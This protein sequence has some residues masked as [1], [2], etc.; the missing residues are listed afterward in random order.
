MLS[1]RH[2]YN[3]GFRHY[4]HH[5]LF[6]TTAFCAVSLVQLTVQTSVDLRI[7]AFNFYVV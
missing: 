4:I 1:S 2:T 5:L 7:V 3:V 6:S